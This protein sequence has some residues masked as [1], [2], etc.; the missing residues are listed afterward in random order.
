VRHERRRGTWACTV[1]VM[2]ETGAARRKVR[3]PRLPASASRAPA[4]GAV[5]GPQRMTSSWWAM[6]AQSTS[7]ASGRLARVLPAWSCHISDLWAV[8]PGGRRLPRKASAL[9]DYL[10]DALKARPI[11]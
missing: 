6:I 3:E 4:C 9:L 10:S 8:W 2:L 1:L 11:A 7:C 5:G